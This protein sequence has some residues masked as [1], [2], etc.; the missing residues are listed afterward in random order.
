MDW[1]PKARILAD[2]TESE[3]TKPT[4]PG[5]DGFVGATSAESPKIEA[6]P[7]PAELARA[8]DVL[9]RTGVRILA[10][11]GGAAIGV[12]IDLD[13]PEIRAALRTLGMGGLPVRY[14]DGDGVPMRYKVRR[15][16]GDPVPMNV[17][18]EMELHPTEPWNVRDRMLNEMGWNLKRPAL[19]KWKAGR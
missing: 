1:T 14:L 10:L 8:C 5:F 18:A 15:V 9:N 13:G 2:F 3:P 4:E 7:C 16:E 19:T 17:L 6:G 11:E 12:W